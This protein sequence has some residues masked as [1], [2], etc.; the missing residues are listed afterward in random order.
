MNFG[1]R[2]IELTVKNG[3]GHPVSRACFRGTLQTPGR[4]IPWTK[5]KFEY[6]IPGGLE[7]GEQ[8]E[9]KIVLS[10]LSLLSSD[11]NTSVN[12]FET[13]EQPDAV[14][15]VEAIRLDGADGEP[16]LQGGFDDRDQK[17]L[18]SLKKQLSESN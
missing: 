6:K 11:A 10:Y 7:P 14:L 18:D 12:W 15:H 4:T 13:E 3:A 8:A 5:G 16:F 17:K 1:D 9:W 2:I